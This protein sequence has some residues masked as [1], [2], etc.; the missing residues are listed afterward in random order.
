MKKCDH[1]SIGILVWQDSNLLLIER[2]KFPFGFGPP[3]GHCDGDDFETAARRELEEEVGLKA[4]SLR[5]VAEGRRNNPC[6][7]PEGTWHHWKIYQ[8]EAEGEVQRS[9]EETKQ[10][11]WYP[12]EQLE[13]LARRTE[14][15]LAGKIS[16]E[17]WQKSPGIEPVWYQWMK[18]LGII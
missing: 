10:T 1:T 6:R 7:R 18:E 12:K 14:Q 17:E 5:L 15:Y 2:K 8:A 4:T 9:L 3:A 16:E 11:G 13:D